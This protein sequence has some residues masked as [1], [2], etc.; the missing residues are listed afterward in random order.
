MR[1]GP[2]HHRILLRTVLENEP[3]AHVAALFKWLCGLPFIEWTRE[4]IYPH[5]LAR[6]VLITELRWR[7]PEQYVALHHRLRAFYLENV[8]ESEADRLLA[9]YI[10]LHRD[11]PII[12]PF[13]AWQQMGNLHPTAF[14]AADFGVIKRLVARYEGEE[15]AKWVYYWMK[16]I[17]HHVKVWR[18]DGKLV[19]YLLTLTLPDAAEIGI[20]RDP[21]VSAIARYLYHHAPLRGNEIALIFRFWGA[22]DS[23]QDVSAVQSAI[24]LEMVRCYL[25]TPRLA[26]SFFICADPLFWANGMA[27]ADLA[28]VSSAEFS[29]GGHR[30]GVYGHDW[31]VTPPSAWL[32]LLAERELGAA[33][34]SIATPTVTEQVVLTEQA[35]A[36]AV[37]A[38]LHHLT[39]PQMLTQN[40]LCHARLISGKTT[41]RWTLR[42]GRCC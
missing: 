27:Y 28:H 3:A 33:G 4:G 24:F 31:R 35:F 42:R 16:R 41:C 9:D 15:S 36:E 23:Y 19:G 26:Y 38:A 18:E 2:C 21:A 29:I 22:A 32:N 14:E 17:P 20:E 5:D 11:N 6:E 7:N 37:R 10:Y 1:F 40:P 13:F 34:A 8:A 25:H 12:R 39:M 30:Y